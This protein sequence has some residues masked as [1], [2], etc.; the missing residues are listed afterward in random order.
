[1]QISDMFGCDLVICAVRYKCLDELV[2]EGTT[3]FMFDEP[4]HFALLFVELLSGDASVI[5]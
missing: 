2:E 4:E 1:M 5:R 3:G